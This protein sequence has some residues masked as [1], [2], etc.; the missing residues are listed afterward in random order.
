M[1]DRK[2][3]VSHP[4]VVKENCRRR[5]A[6]CDVDRLVKLEIE[7]AERQHTAQELNRLANEVS[8]SIGKAIDD[9]DRQTRITRGRELRDQK[10][11]AQQAHDQLEVEIDELIRHLPNLTHPDVP[12]GGEED[13][14]EVG[15]GKTVIRSLD[16]KAKDHLELGQLHDLFDF[17]AGARVAG[18]GFYFLKNAAVRLDLA[19]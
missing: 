13:A 2:F 16:F 19:L 17:E 4:E 7:R 6:T 8:Q 10:D 9:A 11:A 15:R 14:V 5:G 18:A 1:L 3:I 12:N